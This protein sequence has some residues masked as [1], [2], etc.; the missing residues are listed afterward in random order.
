MMRSGGEG[1]KGKRVPGGTYVLFFY[2]FTLDKTSPH[3]YNARKAMTGGVPPK[4]NRK[5]SRR[6]WKRG[7]FA[8]EKNSPEHSLEKPLRPSRRERVRPIQRREIVRR[9]FARHCFRERAG[10]KR[11]MRVVPRKTK[12]IAFHPDEQSGRKAFLYPETNRAHSAPRGR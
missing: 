6:W 1:T 12:H 5:E 4:P 8:G 9:T 10:R 7:R 11:P 3:R 2:R